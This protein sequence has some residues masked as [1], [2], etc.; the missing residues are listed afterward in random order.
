MRILIIE[1]DVSLA[2]FLRESLL[3]ASYIVD[4]TPDGERGSYLAR[5]NAYDLIV[6]DNRLPRKDGPWICSEMRAHGK[7]SPILIISAEREARRKAE[8]LNMGADDYLEK[9]FALDEFMARVQALLR[10]PRHV[11]GD[12]LR[13]GI[14]TL[15]RRKQV[16]ERKGEE[17]PL[18]RKEFELL[19]YLMHHRGEIVSRGMLMEHVWDMNGDPFSNTIETHIMNVRKKIKEPYIKTIIGRGYRFVPVEKKQR[20]PSSSLYLEPV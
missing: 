14:L 4:W 9:P 2:G 12:V 3:A 8:L 5:T 18:T 15:D 11:E 16:I 17:L 7:T 6:L 10:R 13:A 19:E 20:I 1:D